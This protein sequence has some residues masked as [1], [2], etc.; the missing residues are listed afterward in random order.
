MFVVNVILNYRHKFK[1][2]TIPVIFNSVVEI[3]T[4]ISSH[5]S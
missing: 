3:D 2:V 1:D 4:C 5:T